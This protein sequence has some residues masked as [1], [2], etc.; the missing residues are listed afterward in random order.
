MTYPSHTLWFD[1]PPN[2]RRITEFAYEFLMSLVLG[3]CP[4]NVIMLYL[5]TDSGIAQWS[6]WMIGKSSLGRGWKFFSSTGS[7]AHPTCYPMRNVGFSLGIK[8]PGREADHPPSSRPD[9]KN[10]WRYT[11]A[12][13]YAFM[14]WCSVKAQGQLYIY[15]YH[16]VY[17]D[18]K[19]YFLYVSSF[20]AT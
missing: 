12:P 18:R 9:V 11:S 3:S 20:L 5:T 2:I 8:Q 6:G 14:A 15:L 16:F 4:T 17:I 13:Q 19:Y 1:H 10:E 7:G